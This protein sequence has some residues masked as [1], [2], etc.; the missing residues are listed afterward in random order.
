LKVLESYRGSLVYLQCT[1]LAITP[2]VKGFHLTNDS[3]R[4]D[5]DEEGWH[6]PKSRP[7]SDPYPAA[8]LHVDPVPRLHDNV[9]ALQTLFSPQEPPVQY[10]HSNSIR[11]AIYW[12]ADVSRGG[13][14]SSLGTATA[15]TYAHGIW[16]GDPGGVLSNYRELI[17][18]VDTLEQG[19]Q[20]GQLHHTE[21]WIFTDNSTSEEIFGKGTHTAPC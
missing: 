21:V 4:P 10:V 13:F 11:T 5:H 15:L 20:L 12:Y 14:G 19:A 7:I 3:W 17:N 2:Y 1:Y 18:L 9:V 16:D 8:P 6:L